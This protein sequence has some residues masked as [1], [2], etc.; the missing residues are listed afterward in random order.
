MKPIS[1]DKQNSLKINLKMLH[2]LELKNQKLANNLKQH[3]RHKLKKFNKLLMLNSFKTLKK[4]KT[5]QDIL[6]QDL[7]LLMEFVLMN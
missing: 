5:Y 2:K 4:L 3:G 7:L 6:D 1:K